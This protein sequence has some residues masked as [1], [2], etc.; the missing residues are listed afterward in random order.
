MLCRKI[1]EQQYQHYILPGLSFVVWMVF[2][3]ICKK[4][5]SPATCSTLTSAFLAA[6]PI[7]V[8]RQCILWTVCR[9]TENPATLHHTILQENDFFKAKK[10]METSEAELSVNIHLPVALPKSTLNTYSLVFNLHL[11][12]HYLSAK[13]KIKKSLPQHSKS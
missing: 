13:N 10:N 8:Y 6:G 9:R 4:K 11:H 7:D 12:M 1:N 3:C 5:A 2:L